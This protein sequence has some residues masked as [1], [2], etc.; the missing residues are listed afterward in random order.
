MANAHANAFRAMRGV[1]LTACLDI[2]P[3][4]AAQ[5][6]ARHG[7][8]HAVSC[9]DQLLEEV[10][11]VSVVTP[12]RFHAEISLKVLG[13]GKHL[14]CEKPLSVTLAEAKDVAAAARAASAR[15]V[16][17]VINLTYRRSA[18][19]ERAGRLVSEGKLGRLRHVHSFYLQTWLSAPVWGH[20]TEDTW[21]WRLQ[22]AAGSGGVLADIGCHILDITT[23]VAGDARRIRCDL[24]TFPKITRDGKAVTRWKGRAL[25]ANDTAVIE[26]EFPGGAVAVIQTT[27]WAT[28]HKNHVRLEAHGTKGAVM[29]DLDRSFEDLEACLGKDVSS[30][31]W[32]TLTCRPALSLYE[33]FIHSIHTGVNAQ[34]DVIRGAQVQALLD[35]CERSATSGR[36]EEVA[37]V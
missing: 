2:V 22:A 25:D 35:A 36:W 21:L 32:R 8:R 10:D 13:A 6:A 14:L 4:R 34:P 19:L 31:A 16:I 29:L 11:A 18:A 37:E 9:L 12:D 30:A 23:A 28:G 15:G 5:F 20:W 24:R 33:R 7:V 3:E 26:L 1:E 17:H 27:R